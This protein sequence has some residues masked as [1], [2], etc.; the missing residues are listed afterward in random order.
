MGR[1]T[2]NELGVERPREHGEVASCA[3][4]WQTQMSS[5]TGSGDI[6]QACERPAQ[7]RAWL[8]PLRKPARVR[9]ALIASDERG[10]AR[11]MLGARGL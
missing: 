11:G 1:Q 10:P 8:L 6:L 3:I 7:R 4:Q 9:E 2:R 5:M